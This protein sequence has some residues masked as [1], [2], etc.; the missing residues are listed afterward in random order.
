M[1]TAHEAETFRSLLL[2]HRGRTRL[3]QRELATRAGVSTRSLQDW[4]VGVSLPSAER[5]QGLI[6]ALLEAGG[7][8]SGHERSEARELWAAVQREAP[9]LHASFDEEWFSGLL[10]HHVA[11]SAPDRAEQRLVEPSPEPPPA[12]RVRDWGEAPDTSGFVGRADELEALR[13]WVLDER[14]R[15]IAVL[16]MGGIGKTTLA[17]R[18]A[19]EVAPSFERVYW[20]SLRNAPPVDDWLAGAIG[21]LS[22]QQL[23]PESS[24]SARITTLLQMLRSK[25][26]LLVLDNSEALFEPGQ[27]EGQYRAGMDGYGRLLQ[28]VGTTSHRSCLI[29]TSREAPPELTVLGTGVHSLELHGLGSAEAQALLAAK[30]LIGD[31]DAWARLVDRYSGNGLA[32]KIVGETIRQVYGGAVN[33]FLDEAIATYG[34]VFGGIRRLLDVQAERLSPLERSVLQRMAVEREPVTLLELS[35]ALA[36]S[37]GRNSLIE[38]VEN[39]RR[40]SMVERSERGGSFTLQSMVLEYVTDR[41]VETV[42]QEIETGQARVLVEQALIKAQAKEYVRQAQE[43]LIGAPILVRLQPKGAEAQADRQLLALLDGW[44]GRPAAEQGYGPGNVVNLLRLLRGNLQNTDLSQLSIRQA[45]LQEADAH[46]TRLTGADLSESVLAE[47]FYFPAAIAMSADGA[48]VA[49]GTSTGRVGVWRVADRVPLWA[50]AH[51]H[52]GT[53]RGVALSA[54]GRLAAS[55]GGDG[56][57]RIWEA[58]TGEPVVTLEA[59]TSATRGV[60][61]SADGR[62]LASC[63][64]DGVVRLWQT[65]TAD[66]LAILRGHAGT[67]WSVA[68]SGDGQLVASGGEDGSVR[69][70]E[71]PTGRAIAVLAG[72]VGTVWSV[73]VSA[74]RR[75]VASGG[76]DGTLRLWDAAT[77]QP[78]F[79]LDRHDGSTVWGVSLSADGSRIVSGGGNGT[80]RVWDDTGRPLATWQGHAGTVFSVGLSADAQLAASG[81]EDGRLRLWEASAGRP[82]ATLLGQTGSVRGVALSADGEVV[83]GGSADAAIRLWNARTG[84]P[85]AALHGHTGTVW[86]VALSPDGRVL[87]SG[88]EDGS[89]RLWDVPAGRTLAKLEGHVGTVRGVAMSSD[90]QVVASGGT[91]GMVRLWQVET[92]SPLETLQGHTSTVWSVALSADGRLVASGGGDGTVRVWDSSTGQLLGTLE[93]HAGLVWGVAVSADGHLVVSAGEDGTVRLWDPATGRAIRVLEGHIGTVRGVALSA[94]G[95]LI[96]SGGAD[97]TVRLWDAGTGHPL[98]VLRG[99]TGTVWSVALS[100]DGQLVVSGGFDGTVKV[101]DAQT[102][103]TLRTV[104]GERRYERVDIAGLTGVTDA[105]RQSLVALGAVD[106]SR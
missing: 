31:A 38:A 9:R 55:G 92:R 99:H 34:T 68:I 87:V 29:L 36:L 93:G 40:R 84:Q 37:L 106:R 35:R 8:V 7:L 56:K 13:G 81:G 69:L 82:L 58:A 25:R 70:W 75:R 27:G 62:W 12:K 42:V 18:L 96:V 63:G 85:L 24:E 51:G 65:E 3:I 47:S 45:Y 76:G 30:Q 48:L 89:V 102:G 32:L 64:G 59:H 46:D 71:A 57:V 17:A 94:D 19:Q 26:C 101:W 73:A 60:A 44:R 2:R 14:S 97:G 103:A 5:L 67:V 33:E 88:G 50:A 80:V 90:G 15:L 95:R 54:D 39:L 16:G 49:A 21:S 10:A 61:L 83:V 4:E 74:D 11:T 66:S 91:D 22:D 105:Q 1:D 98:N 104:Q 77:G 100:A 79:V 23:V 43:R 41:L 28:A 86:D 72:H 53:I 20:R 6:R 78:L 52:A